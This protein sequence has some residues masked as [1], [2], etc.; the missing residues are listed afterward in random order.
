M[1]SSTA[2]P[3]SAVVVSASPPSAAVASC[4]ARLSAHFAQPTVSAALSPA[5]ASFL[6]ERSTLLRYATARN[7]DYA[8]ALRNLEETLVWRATHVPAA[9]SCP[10]CASDALSHCFFPLG[11]DAHRRVV[12]YASAAKAR[13]NERDVTVQH[14][15]HTLEHAWRATEA[16]DLAAQWVWVIDFGGFSFW[17]AMQGSTSS[18]AMSAFSAHMPERLGAVLLLNPPGVFDMLLAVL[19]PLL[20]ARTMSKV[21]VVRGDAEAV[22]DKLHA[23]GIHRGGADG[24]GAWMAAVLAMPP[25]AGAVP[26]DAGLDQEVLRQ[27]RMLPP[28][29]K[30]E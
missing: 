2:P 1:P 11:L 20:D 22:A 8:A 25:V 5:S 4:V 15:C 17:N 27:I 19:K 7:G 3:P 12:I 9:L 23:V 16:L 14:M 13:I 24:I 26:S 18:G 29:R 28:P 30:V 21:H 6:G 10:A